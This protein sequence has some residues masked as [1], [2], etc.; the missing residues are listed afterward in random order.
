L[1]RHEGKI[2]GIL[3]LGKF[4]RVLGMSEP[5]NKPEI[6]PTRAE[7]LD[8]DEVPNWAELPRLEI[9]DQASA[10]MM[11]RFPLIPAVPPPPIIPTESNPPELLPPPPGMIVVNDDFAGLRRLSNS[12]NSTS[13]RAEPVAPAESPEPKPPTVD[14]PEA[15]RGQSIVYGIVLRNTTAETMHD[16]RIE[17]ELPPGPRYIGSDPPAKVQGRRLIWDVGAFEPGSKQRFKITIQPN[18]PGEV[19]DDATGLF[20]VH[21]SLRSRRRLL[22]PSVTAKLTVP[23]SANTSERFK[24]AVEIH[25]AG[26]GAAD[27]IR[28]LVPLPP[29]LTH[30]DGAIVQF[31]RPRLGPDEH[32]YFEA[33]VLVERGGEYTIPAHAF[34]NNKRLA[35]AQA[36]LKVHGPLEPG[37]SATGAT[38][39][40]VADAPA[41]RDATQS[42]AQTYML[43]EL[44]DDYFAVPAARVREV[45]R[46]Q[47]ATPRPGA[48]VW[49]AGTLDLWGAAV[50]LID[51]RRRLGRNADGPAARILL[52]TG[53]EPAALLIDR[54]LGVR[55]LTSTPADAS[56]GE[57]ARAIS[58]HDGR[59]VTVLDLDRLLRAP[60]LKS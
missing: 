54:A 37:T 8:D 45:R 49:L 40:P 52:M 1:R 9:G 16:V 11:I 58:S 14:A 30:A 31:S 44:A 50:P 3:Q 22:R 2:A 32:E 34:G 47:P 56:A 41:S 53:G 43:F 60:E 29:G 42:I 7:W 48:P 24:L 10:S 5:A 19:S 59:R 4:C 13:K 39:S 55:R 18:R 21:Q 46:A 25:N 26:P 17:H 33:E 28:V 27:E 51:L 20:E 23:A 12:F 35:S 6:T 15:P 36:T 38:T 57:F